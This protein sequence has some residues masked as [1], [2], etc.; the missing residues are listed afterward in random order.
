MDAALLP[1]LGFGFFLGLLPGVYVWFRGFHERRRLERELNKLRA[2]V[3]A[4]IELSHEGTVQ[5][6]AEIERLQKENEN[7]RVTVKAWQQKPDR[8][9]LRQLHV[10]DHAVREL[11]RNAPGFA[12]HWET[13]LLRAETVIGE[14]DRGLLAFSRRL[15]LRSRGPA[16]PGDPSS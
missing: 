8:S 10:Y 4:H 7:L 1:I 13:S 12:A 11:K 3:D 5:R 14:E 9:E 6:K 15:F 2:H 16:P